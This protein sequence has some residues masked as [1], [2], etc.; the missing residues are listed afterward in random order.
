MMKQIIAML[1]IMCSGMAVENYTTCID[2]NNAQ[3]NF[4]INNNGNTTTISVIGACKYG[5]DLTMN[6]CNE[7]DYTY[8]LAVIIGFIVAIIVSFWLAKHFRSGDKDQDF[9]G[10]SLGFIF[11]MLGIFLTLG[12]LLYIS[13]SVTGFNSSFLNSS[14]DMML[15][16][17]N[18]WGIIIIVLG[19]FLV[20]FFLT[21]FV[22]NK[23]MDKRRLWE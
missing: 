18:I 9:S 3:Q 2:A 17:S 5:C 14:S 21:G 6:K 15:S 22:K 11:L 10:I 12:L 1:L 4:T 8:L 23:L 20:L 13:G 19:F 7:V 16:I